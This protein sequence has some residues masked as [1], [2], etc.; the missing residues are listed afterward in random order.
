ML[1]G[2]NAVCLFGNVILNKQ[3]LLYILKLM[4]VRPALLC[5]V[6]SIG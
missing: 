5:W 3:V 4:P 1:F 2:G 6:V